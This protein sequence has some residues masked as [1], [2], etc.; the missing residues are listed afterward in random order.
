MAATGAEVSRHHTN[1]TVGRCGS[2]DPREAP[3]RLVDACD[4][5]VARPTLIPDESTA[6]LSADGDVCQEID[7]MSRRNG[8][9]TPSTR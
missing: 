8:P 2:L 1:V 4:V 5:S 7:R 3:D 6:D 9:S